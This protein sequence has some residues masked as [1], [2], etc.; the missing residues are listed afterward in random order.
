MRK[1]HASPEIHPNVVKTRHKMRLIFKNLFIR[2]ALGEPHRSDE[3]S[4]YVTSSFHGSS[5]IV[6]GAKPELLDDGTRL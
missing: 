6:N 4:M 2:F 1:L 3:H 5:G